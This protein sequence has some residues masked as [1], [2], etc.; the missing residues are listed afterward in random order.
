MRIF[1][2]RSQRGK[3]LLKRCEALRL[4]TQA[5]LPFFGLRFE[6]VLLL[7]VFNRSHAVRECLQL[8]AAKCRIQR[9]QL[10]LLLTHDEP[11]K[12]D[13]AQQYTEHQK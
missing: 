4:F 5:L 8:P 9:R 1:N 10:Y 12:K 7:P 2:I 6:N 13:C 11:E 3:L